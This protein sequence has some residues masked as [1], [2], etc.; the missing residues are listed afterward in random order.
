MSLLNDK[1]GGSEVV[2]SNGSVYSVIRG[3]L[4]DG[5]GILTFLGESIFI[6]SSDSSCFLSEAV[7]FD[8]SSGGLDYES[9]DYADS[10]VGCSFS[11]LSSIFD[12]I[13]LVGNRVGANG[14]SSS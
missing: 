13:V 1:V 14:G 4:V 6:S 3:F 11:V 10:R 5:S 12:I 2:L 8:N 7:C 9:N